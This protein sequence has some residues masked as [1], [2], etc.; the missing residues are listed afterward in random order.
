MFVT[1]LVT[2]TK[3]YEEYNVYKL[4]DKQMW[5]IHAMEYYLSI[6]LMHAATWMNLKNIK[7]NGKKSSSL[8]GPHMVWFP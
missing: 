3:N 6:I 8:K 4:K 2:I 7:Q 1:A 5:Y